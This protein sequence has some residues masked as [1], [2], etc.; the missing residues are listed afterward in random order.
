MRWAFEDYILDDARRE[1]WRGTEAIEIE[2]QVFDLLAYLVLNPDRVVTRDELL[3]AIWDGRFVS[4][5]AI[6]NRINGARRAIGDSGDAQRLIRTVPRKGFRFIATVEPCAAAPAKANAP[7]NAVVEQSAERRRISSSA[8]AGAVLVVLST[9]LA[10]LLLWP[11]AGDSLGKMARLLS[12]PRSLPAPMKAAGGMPRL[13]I[14]VLPLTTLGNGADQ[15]KLSDGVT[16]GLTTELSRYRYLS[17]TSTETAAAYAQKGV[18][19]KQIGR[20]L[21]VRYIVDGSIEQTGGQVR[22]TTRVADTGSG[23][24]LWADRY[25]RPSGDLLSVED[26]IVGRMLAEVRTAL[27]FSEASRPGGDDDP[28]QLTWRARA[29]HDMAV[30][31]KGYA[32]AAQAYERVLNVAPRWLP[33]RIGLAGALAVSVHGP[34]GGVSDPEAVRHAEALIDGALIAVPRDAGAHFQHGQVLRVE[35]HCDEA[36]HELETAIDLDRNLVDAYSVLGQCKLLTGELAEAITLEEKAIRLAPSSPFVGNRYQRIGMAELLQS[37]VDEAISW[38]EKARANETLWRAEWLTGTDSGLAAAY[39]LN[40]EAGRAAD[41]LAEARK[42]DE[43]PV[44]IDALCRQSPLCST[45]K[46]RALA[47]PTYLKGLRLAG[48]PES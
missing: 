45:P 31:R 17:V 30:S 23:S 13:T 34:F 14:A 40:G 5:S 21:G 1:L 42:S 11:G 36:I 43:H 15:P 19:A 28:V 20:E 25:D 32:D 46:M 10:G 37:N 4:E 26:E 24:Y 22:V 29:L 38:L 47:E 44:S 8:I 2:P 16:E 6:A 39:A 33:A 12:G 18:E 7:V 48:L 27:T 3:Q 41:A 9:A 35:G